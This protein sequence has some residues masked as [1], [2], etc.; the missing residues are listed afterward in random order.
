MMSTDFQC[1]VAVLFLVFNRPH[2][3]DITFEQIR[4]VRPPRLYVHCDGARESREGER[5]LVLQSHKIVE[6]VD[7]PCE[8]FTLFRTENIGLRDALYGAISW[9]FEQE[10]AGIIL[11]D[12]C[13]ADISFFQF[14][15]ELLE[16]Y[17]HEETVMHIGGSNLVMDITRHLPS[18]YF[19]SRF[20]LVWGWATWRRAWYKMDFEMLH[21]GQFE[22]EKSIQQ[23]LP[24]PMAQTYMLEKFRS[25]QNGKIS[26][27]AYSWFYSILKNNGICIVP[28]INL[29]QNIGIGVE[30][31]TNTTQ[32]DSFSKRTFNRLSFPLRHPKSQSI[33]TQVEIQLFYFTQKKKFRLWLWYLLHAL[34]LR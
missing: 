7:W 18:D 4:A 22:E 13:C 25:V 12:D 5:N 33:N 29:I 21:L 20:S 30:N 6:K 15:S 34:K 11:E 28:T 3:A 14:C 2:L 31:A 9:F 26:S 17:A 19:W 1:P 24:L 8:V 27:W 23:L 16:K 32:N 10:I